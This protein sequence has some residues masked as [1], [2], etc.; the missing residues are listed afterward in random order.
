MAE[1]ADGQ[2][3]APT[4]PCPKFACFVS[5]ANPEYLFAGIIATDYAARIIA[6]RFGISPAM[7]QAIASLSGLGGAQ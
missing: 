1:K 3:T 4:A 6:A 2:E 5:T 7:A